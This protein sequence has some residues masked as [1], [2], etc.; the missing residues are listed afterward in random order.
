MVLFP[1]GTSDNII[2]IY[3][4]LEFISSV[5]LHPI[6]FNHV[7]NNYLSNSTGKD[8]IARPV[9]NSRSS[10][11]LTEYTKEVVARGRDFLVFFVTVNGY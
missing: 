4:K 11:D 10:S 3:E 2:Y 9:T 8:N 5:I 7:A 6:T 1:I